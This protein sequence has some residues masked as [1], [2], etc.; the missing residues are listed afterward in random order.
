M[1]HWSRKG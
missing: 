1:V